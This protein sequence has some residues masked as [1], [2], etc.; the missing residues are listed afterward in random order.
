MK[1]VIA[2]ITA[3]LLLLCGCVGQDEGLFGKKYDKDQEYANKQLNSLL[4]AIDNKD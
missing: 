4:K 2:I 1:K 3:L